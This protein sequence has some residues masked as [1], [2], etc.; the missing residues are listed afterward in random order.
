[1]KQALRKKFVRGGLIVWLAL[2]A[3]ESFANN[4]PFGIDHRWHY[5]NSGIWKRSY[6]LDLLDT[7]IV[8]EFAGGLYEGGHNRL[9]RT[10]WQAIDSSILAGASAQVLK[11]VFTRAR[12]AQ[13]NDPNKFFQGGS[14]YSFPSGEV[15]GVTSI[16]TP[17]VLEYRHEYPAIYALEALP[18]YDAVARMKVQGHWQSDV[19]AG[20]ALGTLTGWY[21]HSRKHPFFLSILPGSVAVGLKRRF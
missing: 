12:P 7:M 18:L 16:V 19:L 2:F 14:H 13:S 8:G 17:F 3:S 15:A 9:G 6:Q 1:M 11:Y 21:A 5:D 20:F 10:Y 4:G